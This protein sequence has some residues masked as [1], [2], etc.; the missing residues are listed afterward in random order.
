MPKYLY[1]YHGGKRPDTEAEQQRVMAAWGAWME[2]LGAGLADGGAP[3]GSSRTVTSGGVADDGGANPA[4]GYS[5]V[6]AAS[7]DAAVEMARGCPILDDGGSVEVA[8]IMS[9]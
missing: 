2:G 3:V 9:M 5:M 8:E 7:H 1:V 4:S 6:E